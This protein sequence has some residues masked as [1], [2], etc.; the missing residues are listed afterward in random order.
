MIKYDVY[1]QR[2]KQKNILYWRIS[3][4][5]SGLDSL[6]GKK[7]KIKKKIEYW[8]QSKHKATAF[9]PKGIVGV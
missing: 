3:R 4:R 8:K 2:L 5:D 7:K 9:C 1:E 6:K